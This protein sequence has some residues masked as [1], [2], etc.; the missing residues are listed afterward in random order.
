MED[1]KRKGTN[2]VKYWHWKN[3]GKIATL[4]VL[5]PTQK[6]VIY[7]CSKISHPC[8]AR[9]HVLRVHYTSQPLMG[10][11]FCLT[12]LHS[13]SKLPRNES[14]LRRVIPIF[15]F[16]S[17]WGEVACLSNTG[18]RNMVPARIQTFS[19]LSLSLTLCREFKSVS[20]PWHFSSGSD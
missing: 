7:V 12:E 1:F 10:K 19:T 16:T 13:I 9:L 20:C 2:F 3:N 17:P 5:V 4:R 6:D 8:Y 18:C 14:T 11:L 15:S